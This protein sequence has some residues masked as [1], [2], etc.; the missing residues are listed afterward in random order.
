MTGD[1]LVA[2][3]IYLGEMTLR[4]EVSPERK[5]KP[6]RITMNSLERMLMRH[7]SFSIQ[8][9]PRILP[10]LSRERFFVLCPCT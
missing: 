7:V 5:Q 6:L 4:E 3:A 8:C 2:G 10:N 1:T 9:F